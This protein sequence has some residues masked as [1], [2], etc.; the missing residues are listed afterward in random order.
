MN[1]ENNNTSQEKKNQVVIDFLDEDPVI[2]GQLFCVLSFLSPEGIKN[3]S[4][5]GVKIRGVYKS[6]EEAERKCTELR[7]I[8]KYF[9]IYVCEVG[10]WCAWDDADKSYNQEYNNKQLNDLMKSY[11]ENK[12][13]SSLLYEQRKN[14]LMRGKYEEKRKNKLKQKL[15]KKTQP[16]LVK[17][18]IVSKD[19]E[20]QERTL[21]EIKKES[22]IQQ[23]KIELVKNELI[24][25][26]KDLNKEKKV[27]VDM[28]E[29]MKKISD[30][31]DKLNH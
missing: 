24:K 29:R 14:E 20:P 9:D 26:K 30:I 18:S 4:M 3:C 15:E 8:D 21:E 7:K 22:E 28:E 17:T 1:P 16:T 19:D 11:K 10:K 6:Q 25:E 5:R 2:P 13:K 27:V 12:D 31:Y 23:Q